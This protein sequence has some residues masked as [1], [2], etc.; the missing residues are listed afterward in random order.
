MDHGRSSNDVNAEKV[1][2]SNDGDML[3]IKLSCISMNIDS[4]SKKKNT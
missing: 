3:S 1:S 4:N 2:S